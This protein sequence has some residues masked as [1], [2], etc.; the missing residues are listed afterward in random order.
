MFNIK[1]CF[2]LLYS[3]T[4]NS[5]VINKYDLEKK[6]CLKIEKFASKNNIP[7]IGRIPYRKDFVDS[8]IKMKPVIEINPNYKKIFKEII[9]K[10][11]EHHKKRFSQVS[12]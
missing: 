3:N 12:S 5:I 9:K 6:F 8:T 11:Y 4:S 10:I 1:V 7:I 2:P